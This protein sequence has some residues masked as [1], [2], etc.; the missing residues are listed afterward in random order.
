MTN[1][2]VNIL[3]NFLTFVI[4]IFLRYITDFLYGKLII[5]ACAYRTFK[6]LKYKIK[7][8]NIER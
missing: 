7:V 5:I 1:K 4:F 2:I 3:V 6:L 8:K